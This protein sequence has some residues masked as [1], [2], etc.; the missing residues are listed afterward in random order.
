MRDEVSERSQDVLED[1]A[2]RVRDGLAARDQ[3]LRLDADPETWLAIGDDERARFAKLVRLA[4]LHAPA[5]CELLLAAARPAERMA[6]AGAGRV[7]LR[8]QLALRE[9][10]DPAR[11]PGDNVVPLRVAADSPETWLAGTA[12]RSLVA[13][14]RERGFRLDFEVLGRGEELCA[15]LS[16]PV[17]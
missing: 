9:A 4:S 8:W 17:R 7:V 1:V 3:A 16:G 5:G 12:I 14:F 15:T 2:A 10:D 13:D 11:S 6:V